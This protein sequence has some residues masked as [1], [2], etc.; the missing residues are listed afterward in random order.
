M[1]EDMHKV[2]LPTS[3][4]L[5]IWAIHYASMLV[6]LFQVGS[7]DGKT[8]YERR[9]GK[10]YR[11][12]LPRFSEKIMYMLP[13]K[14][15]QKMDDRYHYGIYLGVDKR[16]NE[17]YVADENGDVIRPSSIKRLSHSQQSDP[18]MINKLRGVPWRPTY[19][20]DDP[21][22]PVVIAAEP[23][24]ADDDVPEVQRPERR[25]SD[26]RPPSLYIKNADFIKN[27]YTKCCKG[28]NAA[29]GNLRAV[30]HSEACRI[31]N[32]Q[33]IARDA[34]DRGRLDE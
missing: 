27:G 21:E 4:P 1:S 17:Y 33:A 20:S 30:G 31:K 10:K 8:A 9:K 19:N 11:R 5:L 23:E 14:K 22:I 7:K 25:Q 26:K 6:N 15:R 3:H 28:C 29:R 13:G 16:A 2:K 32:E 12:K 24:A 18:D 34:E